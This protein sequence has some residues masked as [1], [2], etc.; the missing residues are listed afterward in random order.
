MR[1]LVLIGGAALLIGAIGCASE[2]ENKRAK[3][4]DERQFWGSLDQKPDVALGIEAAPATA[5]DANKK[6]TPTGTP[7]PAVV[8]VSGQASDL[9][10]DS[11]HSGV[12]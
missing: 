10:P 12:R 8:Q 2:A 4:E 9:T 5:P 6:P 11:T 3:M 7:A 1:Y